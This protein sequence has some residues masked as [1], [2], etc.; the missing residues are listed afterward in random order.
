[1]TDREW[2]VWE[3]LWCTCDDKE[4]DAPFYVDS[5]DVPDVG[6]IDH[7]GWVCPRCKRYVQLG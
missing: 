6:F 2:E 4:E 5:W 1:M 7:H 3:K